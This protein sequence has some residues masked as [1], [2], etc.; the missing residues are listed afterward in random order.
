MY[1]WLFAALIKV[2]NLNRINTQLLIFS[3]SLKKRV[4]HQIFSVVF[5]K[6]T[7]YKKNK[8]IIK[9]AFYFKQ[10]YKTHH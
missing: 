9:T 3:V 10:I 8:Q 5:I 1:L 7:I 6:V 4:H 2:N